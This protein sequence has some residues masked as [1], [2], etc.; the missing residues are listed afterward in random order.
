[1]LEGKTPVLGLTDGDS[2][3]HQS[4][5]DTAAYWFGSCLIAAN[6]GCKQQN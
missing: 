2:I 6:D 1:M 3:F 4:L 5:Q